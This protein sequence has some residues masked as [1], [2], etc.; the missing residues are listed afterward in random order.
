MS[1]PPSGIGS[2]YDSSSGIG[3]SAWRATRMPSMFSMRR[4]TLQQPSDTVR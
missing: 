4:G 1:A 3:E 2:Q